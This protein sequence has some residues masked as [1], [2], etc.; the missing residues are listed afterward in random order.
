MPAPSHLDL[1]LESF[2]KVLA[3]IAP[4]D[5]AAKSLGDSL[6]V[7][8]E[9]GSNDY[10]F[11]FFKPGNPRETPNQYMPIVVG[12]IGAAVQEVISLGAKA[13]LV[14]G[15]FPIGCVPQYLSM[16]QSNS[17]LDYDEHGCLVWFNN[18]S[19][20]HNQL[21]QQEVARLRSQNPGIKI[22]YADYF[23]AAMQF[24]QTAQSYGGQY[25]T[26]KGYDKAAKIWGNPGYFAS[27]DGI[28]M[29]EKAYSIIA[30]GVLNG[31]Y[32]D[33]PLLKAC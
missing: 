18:F 14:P 7:M 26:G 9:I 17:I 31:S 30:Q 32:A 3:R 15:N 8:D 11:W 21:L 28:H 16:F 10:N 29:T 27:W 5:A 2:K 1:Q 6:V 24:V 22:I 4:G 12:H 33:T 25:H 20:K 13:V 23:G 19:K